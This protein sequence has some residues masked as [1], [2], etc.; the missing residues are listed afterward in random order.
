MNSNESI[1]SSSLT[2]HPYYAETVIS[3]YTYNTAQT[4]PT[5]V[6][7]TIE[8]D[9][10][11]IP[12]PPATVISTASVTTLGTAY[13]P[14]PAWSGGHVKIECHINCD[15]ICVVF[16]QPSFTCHEQFYYIAF[17]EPKQ[18]NAKVYAEQFASELAI[19]HNIRCNQYRRVNDHTYEMKLDGRNSEDPDKIVSFSPEHFDR[20]VRQIWIAK[21]FS[22]TNDEQDFVAYCE[23]LN[24]PENT[25]F[26]GRVAE[27]HQ[28]L[29]LDANEIKHISG[30][31]LDNCIEN[32]SW[33]DSKWINQYIGSNEPITYSYING[34]NK[35]GI[36][37]L[38]CERTRFTVQTWASG[39]L[40]KYY[41][42]FNNQEGSKEKAFDEALEFRTSE[43]Y[44]PNPNKRRRIDTNLNQSVPTFTQANKRKGPEP[45]TEV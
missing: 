15:S 1:C 9:P 39:R 32:L 43:Q 11:V 18:A 12:P 25:K 31:K 33:I 29:L 2:V 24:M 44:K 4:V 40:K 42:Y 34:N 35:S 5:V 14:L 23:K 8:T 17:D 27:M 41:F 7:T 30:D 22:P 36:K 3:D 13:N 19:L 37:H 45:Y 10:S 28:F 38:H 16:D 21:N 6:A 20:V 26:H